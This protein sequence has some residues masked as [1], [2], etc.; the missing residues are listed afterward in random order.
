VAGLISGRSSRRRRNP[1]GSTRLRV[2]VAGTKGHV[3]EPMRDHTAAAKGLERGTLR[4]G[5]ASADTSDTSASASIRATK[6][7]RGSGLGG[8]PYPALSA[9]IERRQI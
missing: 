1:T 2:A 4:R 5:E 8:A 7:P 6:R 3:R 9:V